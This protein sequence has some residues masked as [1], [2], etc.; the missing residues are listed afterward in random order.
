MKTA[1]FVVHL[2]RREVCGPMQ[3]LRDEWVLHSAE[4]Y[5]EGPE[6]LTGSF[7]EDVMSALV[8]KTSARDFGEAKQLVIDTV[9]A[10]YP[11][12]RERQDGQA[13]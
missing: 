3:T 4:V 1:Y 12:L 6:T 5:S 9:A 2:K 13:K 11:W 8:F 10:R 7:G